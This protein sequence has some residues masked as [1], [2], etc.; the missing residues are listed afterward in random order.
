MLLT[1]PVGGPLGGN[2]LFLECRDKLTR[3]FVS[4]TEIT[5]S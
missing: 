5:S 4:L 1:V 3:I 2:V